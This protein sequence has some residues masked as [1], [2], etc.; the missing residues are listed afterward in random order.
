MNLTEAT[1]QRGRASQDAWIHALKHNEN[2]SPPTGQWT[3]GD[4]VFI[5]LLTG[6]ILNKIGCFTEEQF[7]ESLADKMAETFAR[8]L[9]QQ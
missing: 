9:Q 7:S 2:L 3:L 8:H 6:N 4:L 5:N 1:K